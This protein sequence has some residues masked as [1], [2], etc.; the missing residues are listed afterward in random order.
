MSGSGSIWNSTAT[1]HGGSLPPGG[2]RRATVSPIWFDPA[3]R[4]EARDRVADLV[5]FVRQGDG[6]RVEPAAEAEPVRGEAQHPGEERLGVELRG[7]S[8]GL[9]ER[10]G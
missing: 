1:A 10:V 4:V 7:I 2:S 5:L 3:R 8:R 9:I 6:A